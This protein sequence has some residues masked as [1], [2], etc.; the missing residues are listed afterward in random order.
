MK[1]STTAENNSLSFWRWLLKGYGSERAGIRAYWN[2]WLLLHA[3][4]ATILAWKLELQPSSA[5][6][7][8]IPFIS[9]LIAITVAW[10]G[11]IVSLLN[12]EEIIELS[13][14]Y[15][16]G[17]E[18]YAFNVQSTVLTLF[19]AVIL[20]TMYGFQFFL[21]PWLPLFIS[22]IVLRD[23]WNVILFAQTLTI[24][25]AKIAIHKK[26]CKNSKLQSRSSTISQ[27]RSFVRPIR[28]RLN[29][30][31]QKKIKRRTCHHVKK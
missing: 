3:V 27:R 22:S 15:H 23:C 18:G 11:N 14:Y 28:T 12:T 29:S 1:K 8:C 24:I 13:T 10:S 16:G 4:I 7:L 19:I 21:C 26:I 20:W 17:I 5:T 2:K 25:R 9:V 31:S 6:S 30:I